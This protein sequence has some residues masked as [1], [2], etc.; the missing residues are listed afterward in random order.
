[1]IDVRHGVRP[2]IGIGT[3]VEKNSGNAGAGDI[4]HQQRCADRSEI[5]ECSLVDPRGGA[6]GGIGG[7]KI[8]AEGS[9]RLS[10]GGQAGR[11]GNRSG[12]GTVAKK[13]SG[14]DNVEIIR[15]RY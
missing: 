1:A 8:H 9:G 4:T 6:G 13:I 5:A 10:L 12:I 3:A 14:R 15:T 7:A 2:E 11:Y